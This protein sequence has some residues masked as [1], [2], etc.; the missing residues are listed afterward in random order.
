MTARSDVPPHRVEQ[1]RRDRRA[2]PVR[3]T[4]STPSRTAGPQMVPR[5]RAH[6]PA[7]RKLCSRRHHGRHR[8]YSRTVPCLKHD[9]HPREPHLDQ[10]ARKR[11]AGASGRAGPRRGDS[12]PAE[13]EWPAGSRQTRQCHPEGRAAPRSLSRP[14][15]A[16]PAPRRPR[17]QPSYGHREWHMAILDH[18]SWLKLL[19][20][21]HQKDPGTVVK[22]NLLPQR[23]RTRAWRVGLVE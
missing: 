4:H 12:A 14:K 2:G 19:S 17:R 20:K 8:P 18:P 22:G 15:R 13:T 5:S 16:R 11:A 7:S 21:H 3:S 1:P 9:R 23:P 10:L 6:S